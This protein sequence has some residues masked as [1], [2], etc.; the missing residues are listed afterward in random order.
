MR[1]VSGAADCALIIPTRDRALRLLDTLSRIAATDGPAV[2]IIVIDNASV[3]GT[4]QRLAA[5]YPQVKVI[6]QSKNHGTAGRNDGVRHAESPIIV[7]LDDDSGPAPGTLEKLIAALRDPSLGIAACPVRL[8]NGVWEE[9]GSR[10]VHIGCGAAMRRRIFLD[11]GG[12]PNEYETY[13]EEY[14]LAYRVLAADLRVEYLD[15]AAV[16][17]EP[18]ARASYDYMVEKLTANNAYLATRFYPWDEAVSF[19]AWT[20]Y[21]YSVFAAKREA[22]TG[23]RRAMESLPEKILRGQAQPHPLPERALDFILPHRDTARA[24]Y[25]LHTAGTTQ[26][27]FLRAG[28]EIPGL[29]RAAR[30]AGLKVEAIYEPD[31]GLFG[32]VDQLFNVP[33][34]PF[35]EVTPQMNA[36]LVI[37][38]TS[39]G[40]IR[41]TLE[42]AAKHRLP[43]PA[44][45]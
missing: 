28:K 20:V 39:P 23:F 36:R 2:E 14:D 21:R 1:F 9:G 3:D 4:P 35:S 8:P 32:G 19:I 12:Y 42:L 22:Q 29:I 27:A 26:I 38:G 33:I 43:A 16:W 41:N 30:N 11:L 25:E 44:V 18:A 37:G 10:H 45:P 6:T 13:V 15:G 7:L 34:R 24:F 31:D 17:H 40:F 5:D